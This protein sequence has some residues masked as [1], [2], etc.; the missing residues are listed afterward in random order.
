M[1]NIVGD[2]QLNMR[3]LPPYSDVVCEFLDYYSDKLRHDK[4]ARAFGDVMSFAF[5][6]RKGNITAKKIQFD[7]CDGSN[8]R[9]GR[10]VVFHIAPSNVPVNCMFTYAFGLLAGNINIVKLPSTDFASLNCM[11]RVLKEVL[12]E[13]NFSVISKM[14]SFVKYDRNDDLMTKEYSSQCDVRV[15]WGGDE[16]INKIRQIY[17]PPRSIELTFADRYSF[18]IVNVPSILKMS[19]S[20][21]TS[22][23]NDFYNDTYLMDQNACSS[24]HLILFHKDGCNDEEIKTAKALF[25]NKV[26]DVATKYELAN[27]KAS[28]KYL[29]L[30]EAVMDIRRGLTIK[31]IK[32]YSNRLYVCD[33]SD[34]PAQAVN[35]CRGRY[36][37]FY[38]CVIDSL[39]FISKLDDKKLQTCAVCGFEEKAVMDYIVKSGM[40]GIDRVVPFGKTLDIDTIWD[41]FDIINAMSRII[42]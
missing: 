13:D 1:A 11:L 18:G 5:W 28:D 36:G 26:S 31:D 2:I 21:L 35:N 12:K 24:P 25:W 38:E 8:R 23:C 33:L 3:A 10:G 27:I 6:A 20:D 19:D 17:L 39:D 4:E 41:G 29:D 16:T 30:C 40:H 42:G 22:V 37:M 9:V 14:T 7:R 32:S 34:V 15:I